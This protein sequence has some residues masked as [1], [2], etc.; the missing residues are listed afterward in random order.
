MSYFLLMFTIQKKLII[1]HIIN[2]KTRAKY[3]GLNFW[4]SLIST[5]GDL[6]LVTRNKVLIIEI[7]IIIRTKPI[8]INSGIERC[9][10]GICWTIVVKF[11]HDIVISLAFGKEYNQPFMDDILF[12]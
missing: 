8:K 3:L 10:R 4:Y 9:I 12:Q 2:Q 6:G 7:K 5:G 1:N 11:L